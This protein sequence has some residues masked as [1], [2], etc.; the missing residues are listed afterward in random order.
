MIRHPFL[1]RLQ[2]CL[3]LLNDSAIGGIRFFCL[4][5]ERSPHIYE[6]GISVTPHSIKEMVYLRLEM[7]DSAR[8][9]V[10]D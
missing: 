3:F 10:K 1:G 9:H 6:V 8:D 7:P 4:L 2:N 5:N